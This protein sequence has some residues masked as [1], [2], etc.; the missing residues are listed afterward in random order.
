M[1]D[2]LKISF[3]ILYLTFN[4][5]MTV[6]FHYCGSYFNHFTIITDPENC[7]EGDCSCCH[8]SSLE[9]K[10]TSEYDAIQY[11]QNTVISLIGDLPTHEIAYSY[12]S[13]EHQP[14]QDLFYPSGTLILVL[15]QPRYLL[16]QVF[17]I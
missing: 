4:T 14:E 9:L 15:K 13:S 16:H 11:D 3:A 17:I 2:A 5:G 6:N 10:I 8:N 12:L 1:K 7:C